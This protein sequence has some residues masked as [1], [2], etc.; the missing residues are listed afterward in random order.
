MSKK[1]IV[2]YFGSWKIYAAGYNIANVPADK[3][4]TLVYSFVNVDSQ[5]NLLLT[6]QW[7]DTDKRF[8]DPGTFVTSA[9]SWNGP[10]REYYGNFG[11]MKDLK[12]KYPN[13]KIEVALGG[14]TLSKNMSDAVLP[15]NQQNFCNSVLAFLQ[16]YTFFTGVTID[17]EYPSS[18]GKNYGN[19]GNVSRTDDPKNFLLFVQKLKS[20]LGNKYDI[21]SCFS[22]DPK[23]LD[24]DLKPFVSLF[25]RF[26]VMTYD[27]NSSSWGDKITGHN[28]NVLPAS[29]CSFSV[30]GAVD[31]M[32]QKGV[33]SEKIVIGVA[34]YSRGFANSKGPGTPCSGTVT[35]MSYEQG[36][37]NYKAL[38][39]PGA[40][41]YF[42]PIAIAS[43]TYDENK[44]FV[45]SYDSTITA[46]I[47]SKLV[48]D[49]NLGGVIM[50]ELAGDFGVT[51]SNSLI[52]Q[53]Y[54]GL[55]FKDYTFSAVP[56]VQKGMFQGVSVPVSGLGTSTNVPS[57]PTPGPSTGPVPS[58]GPSPSV[59]VTPPP[60][61]G[62]PSAPRVPETPSAPKTGQ[63]IS[64]TVNTKAI[65]DLVPG[66]TT[67]QQVPWVNGIIKVASTQDY[68]TRLVFQVDSDTL[69]GISENSEKIIPVKVK[70]I[71]L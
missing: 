7:A 68:Y 3:I 50:W 15:Q 41:E 4:T 43:Y 48:N 16:K 55:V 9:D 42:D 58:T 5:G 14:W 53:L 37:V 38:P 69:F 24:F 12:A 71:Y 66:Q 19:D 32:L 33:P 23:K 62:T 65:K 18:S 54:K 57:A 46:A 61:N 52:A 39:L 26:D 17:W 30:T 56:R 70:R 63:V 11:Q 47:K 49:R 59:P 40:I 36:V 31:C 60:A 28:T 1:E 21:S 64:F 25:K 13:L 2:A 22:A 20:V 51:N 34:A 10:Q 6:D 35:D 44:Q 45:N 27:M 67:M 8:S 29:Y